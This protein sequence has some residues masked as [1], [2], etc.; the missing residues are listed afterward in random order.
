MKN[1]ECALCRKPLP[2]YYEM[3]VDKELDAEIRSKYPEEYA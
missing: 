2:K 3:V 1:C